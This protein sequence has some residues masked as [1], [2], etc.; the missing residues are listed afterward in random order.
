MLD[1][2]YTFLCIEQ[3]IQV[4]T[5]SSHKRFQVPNFLVAAEFSISSSVSSYYF[6]RTSNHTLSSGE[7]S[8]KLSACIIPLMQHHNFLFHS[9]L[10]STC[11]KRLYSNKYMMSNRLIN[12][13]YSKHCPHRCYCILITDDSI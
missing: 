11:E 1:C 4:A 10:Q 12:N 9:P 8:L 7:Y 6:Q 13:L 2:K 3:K 5:T